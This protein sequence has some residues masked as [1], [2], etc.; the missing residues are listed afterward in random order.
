MAARLLRLYPGPPQ[1]RAL[2]G[3]YLAHKLHRLGSAE[4]PFVY[5][6]FV[7]SLDGRIA[8]E[9]PGTGA[10]HLPAGLISGNDFRLLLELQAQA[11]CL[12]THGG[13]LRAIAEGR[14]DDILQVGTR[15][16]AQWRRDNGLAPQPAVAVASASLDFPIPESLVRAEQRVFIATGAAAPA[17]RIE[18]LR[19]RG[20]D[21]IIAGK[22]KS[23]EGAPLTRALGQRG[24]HSLF[25][26]AGPRMLETMLR[27]GMLSRLYI[28]IAHRI[29][30]G[31][32]FHSL[33]SGPE[34]GLAGRLRMTSLYYDMAG[35]GDAGQWF[36]QFEPLPSNDRAR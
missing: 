17:D 15:D 19:A 10:S 21:V 25:L 12:I 24:F 20:Y 9:E 11:D 26:L 3:T 35:P 5:A 30:G 4:A 34:L 33:I 36:A 32:E 7:C 14:L 16:L 6:D 29:L 31:E 8:L 22:G 23:V 27:D 13:Y 28:T 2:A 18:A 1:E